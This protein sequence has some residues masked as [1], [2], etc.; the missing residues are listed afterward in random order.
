MGAGKLFF[1]VF[2]SIVGMG[3]AWSGKRHGNP[4]LFW[5]GLIM[6]VFPY[7]VDNAVALALLGLALMIAP[8]LIRR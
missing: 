8:F 1:E 7:F 6:G 5:C 4:V 3:Y 2:I